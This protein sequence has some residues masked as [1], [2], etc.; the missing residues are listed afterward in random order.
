MLRP[1]MSLLFGLFF[2]QFLIL[3]TAQF[4]DQRARGGNLLCCKGTNNSCWVSV[5]SSP[6]NALPAGQTKVCYCDEYCSYTGDCCPD[7]K[8][9]EAECRG[10]QDCILSPW[11]P[12]SRCSEQCGF[13]TM[14]RR[15]L[16]VQAPKNGG[17]ACP[18]RHEKKGCFNQN[19]KGDMVLAQILPAEYRH[20][21]YATNKFETI[22]PEKKELT[23]I[24]KIRK[25]F[26]SHCVNFKLMSKHPYCKGTWAEKLKLSKPMCVEC[27]P[28]IMDD[29]GFCK[30]EGIVG[31]FTSWV[32]TDAKSC[33]GL[34]MRVG[35]KIPNC[36]CVD[37]KFQNFIFV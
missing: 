34:W 29:K 5:P 36:K 8:R 27:Q 18:M 23:Q 9:V 15:R 37:Q 4:C 14:K 16:I 17:K 2:V 24:Q 21:S 30:G 31:N 7:L 19:C 10:A 32:A 1:I 11:S 26:R 3:S 35:E 22:L 20:Q 13:G 25:R 28:A 33:S 12:W 6:E